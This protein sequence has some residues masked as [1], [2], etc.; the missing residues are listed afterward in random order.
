MNEDIMGFLS[1]AKGANYKRY[2]K[3]LKVRAKE[4][5]KFYP[6]LLVDTAGCV[7]FHGMALTD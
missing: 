3:K 1:V 5:K 2:V 4:E 7:A 6:F